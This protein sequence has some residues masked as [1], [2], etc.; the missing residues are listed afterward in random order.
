MNKLQKLKQSPLLFL[1]ITFK[2]VFT[3][4]TFDV[5]GEFGDGYKES[6]KSCE[7]KTIQDNKKA[8]KKT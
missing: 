3:L 5:Y 6:D 7:N 8:S 2:Y 1:A 4:L